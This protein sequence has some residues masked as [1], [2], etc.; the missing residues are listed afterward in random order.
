MGKYAVHRVDANAGTL[1]EFLEAYGAT[2]KRIGTPLDALCCYHGVTALIEVKTANG[3]LRPGQEKFL[4]E[5]PGVAR[6]L[7][8][9]QDCLNLLSALHVR[10]G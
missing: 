10:S 1:Y 5:W 9:E 2:V 4:R 7:R 8:T 6:I 3:K